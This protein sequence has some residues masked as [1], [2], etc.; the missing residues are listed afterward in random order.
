MFIK[1][2][3]NTVPWTY[4]NNDLNDNEIIGT[5][6]EKELQKTNQH[7]FKKKGEK[8][9]FKWKGFDSSFN[10]CIEKTDLA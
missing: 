3:K 10:S 7:E 4:G 2:I 5:F 9:Y 6:N 1:K 8:L